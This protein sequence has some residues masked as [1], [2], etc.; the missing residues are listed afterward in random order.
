MVELYG[1]KVNTGSNGE[2]GG[3]CEGIRE[4]VSCLPY[5]NGNLPE[6]GIENSSRGALTVKDV[7]SLL[8]LYMVKKRHK[9]E[10]KNSGGASGEGKHLYREIEITRNRYGKPYLKNEGNIHFNVSHSGSWAVGA[11]DSFPVG[12]DVERIRPVNLEIAERF[13]AWQEYEELLKKDYPERLDYFFELWTLKESY[14]K[15]VGRGLSV[16]LG[17]FSVLPGNGGQADSSILDNQ[18]LGCRFKMCAL[19]P[20]Y[21]MAVCS[22]GTNPFGEIR[23]MDIMSFARE[24]KAL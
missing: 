23:L 22:L 6:N 12:I 7:A 4:L 14:I 21:R 5:H 13:F 15:A 10:G 18:D 24:I 20:G 2:V 9:H 1:I 3:E 17:S 16:P 19:E 8:I 11:V